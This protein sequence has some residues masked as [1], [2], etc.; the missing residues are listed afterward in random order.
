M[1]YVPLHSV[2]NFLSIFFV[3]LSAFAG[4]LSVDITILFCIIFENLRHLHRQSKDKIPKTD[5]PIR[6]CWRGPTTMVWDLGW[7]R[8]HQLYLTS[9]I[10]YARIFV[11][12]LSFV[13]CH[14]FYLYLHNN[15]N[16]LVFLVLGL[17]YIL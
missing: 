7:S 5:I 10:T 6:S 15:I 9:S 2:V 4:I 1:Q 16:I 17:P 3:T 12:V 13:L 8:A 14:L 11:M